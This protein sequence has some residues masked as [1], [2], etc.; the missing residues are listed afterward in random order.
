[1][2]TDELIMSSTPPYWN[3][4]HKVPYGKNDAV[5]NAGR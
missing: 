4:M 3:G 5:G 2:D 1:M